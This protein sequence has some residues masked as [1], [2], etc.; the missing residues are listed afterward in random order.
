[1]TELIC[2]KCLYFEFNVCL[3][4]DTVVN[5]EDKACV[6]FRNIPNDPEERKQELYHLFTEIKADPEEIEIDDDPEG[7]L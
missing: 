2:E 4:H 3:F 5:T 6:Y 7:E 1:M